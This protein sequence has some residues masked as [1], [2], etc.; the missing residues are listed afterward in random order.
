MKSNEQDEAR[1]YLI[2][3]I[4]SLFPA[5]SAEYPDTAE[6]GQR[7]LSAAIRD[8]TAKQLPDDWREMPAEILEQYAQ[9]CAMMEFRDYDGCDADHAKWWNGYK[10]AKGA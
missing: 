5:D 4:E 6:I 8:W 10:E 1:K 7:F 9:S 2:D 3:T